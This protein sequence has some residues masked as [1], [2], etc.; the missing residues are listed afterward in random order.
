MIIIHNF[1][2]CAVLENRTH[3]F[4][5][6]SMTLYHMRN[7][8]FGGFTKVKRYVISTFAIT[9]V[10]LKKERNL[11]PI[12]TKHNCINAIRAFCRLIRIVK[13]H[14]D[15]TLLGRHL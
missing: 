1:L 7:K 6:I 11:S 15:L 12:I 13:L 3:D 8:V 14:V 10:E 4:A 2:V 5:L 9:T